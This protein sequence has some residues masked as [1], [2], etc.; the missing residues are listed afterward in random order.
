MQFRRMVL[1]TGVLYLAAVAQ[2]QQPGAQVPAG[3]TPVIRTE[4]KLVLVD[5]VVTDKKGNYIRDLTQKDFRVWE[6]NK[7]QEIKN[8]SFQADPSNPTNADKRY[9]VLFFDNSTMQPADQI[10]AR[11]AAGKFID[12]NAGENRLMAIVNFGGS[13]QIAQNFTADADRL[14]KVVSGV[15]FSSVAPNAPPIE[16]ASIGM[17]TLRN[18]EADF[19]ARSVMLALRS[20]AKN[21][22]SVPGRKTLILFTSGFPLTDEFRPELTAVIDAC[23]RANVAVYPIDV[24]GLVAS[25]FGTI[26]TVIEPRT[27]FQSSRL[28][29]ASFDSTGPARSSN[30]FVRL[31]SFG[32]SFVGQR[33]GGGGGGA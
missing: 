10:R 31:A 16:V 29:A 27:V 11:E 21:L 24:R 6:D 13:V 25:G 2:A 32:N 23:N 14:K 30:S 7:E 1:L 17:P 33:P 15:K 9:L 26:G 12:T 5:T 4:T 3:S 28:M 18:A 22:S 8:F 20:M 19:G